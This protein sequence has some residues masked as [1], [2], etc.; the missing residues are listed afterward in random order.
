MSTS[1]FA[2]TTKEALQWNATNASIG[3]PTVHLWPGQRYKLCV[4]TD[5]LFKLK[6]FGAVA[7]LFVSPVLRVIQTFILS[8][9]TQHVDLV[10]DTTGCSEAG[11]AFLA[12]DCGVLIES[13]EQVLEE[14]D[15]MPVGD[16]SQTAVNSYPFVRGAGIT[17]IRSAP[18]QLITVRC[19][20]SCNASSTA[21]LATICDTSDYS[22]TKTEAVTGFTTAS[23]SL[24][25]GPPESSFFEIVF[26]A[27]PLTPGVA[28]RLCVDLDGSY[29]EFAF[30]DSTLQVHT[31]GAYTTPEPLFG[32]G[33]Q[34]S[35]I[36]DASSLAPGRNY[37]VCIDLDGWA[38]ELQAG[39]TTLSVYINDAK[40]ASASIPALRPSENQSL[41]FTC[42]T[43]C[44]V[45]ST[46]FVAL[47]NV[48]CNGGTQ[49][50]VDGVT[51]SALTPSRSDAGSSLFELSVN[52]TSLIEGKYYTL[53][54][55]TDGFYTDL[56]FGATNIFAYISPTSMVSPLTAQRDIEQ[57][58]TITCTICSYDTMVYL[59][60]ICDSSHG[61]GALPD[62]RKSATAACQFSTASTSTEPPEPLANTWLAA[63]DAKDLTAG[64]YYKLCI[65]VD[66]Q[67][68]AYSYGD[69]GF[70]IYVSP[71]AA[72]D[73]S[74]V[75]RSM[76]APLVV[77]C[78]PF[79]ADAAAL[80]I[81]Y[82][83]TNVSN[84]D[85]WIA[86]FINSH[87]STDNSSKYPVSPKTVCSEAS[88]GYLS[89]SCDSSVADGAVASLGVT[90]SNIAV[91]TS[92]WS[93]QVWPNVF[94]GASLIEASGD[95]GHNDASCAQVASA[96][97]YP[98]WT[99]RLDGGTCWGI[100]ARMLPAAMELPG[101]SSGPSA[102]R[103][104]MASLDTRNLRQG[105]YYKLCFDLDGKN[106]TQRTGDTNWIVFV[107]PVSM[108]FTIAVQPSPNQVISIACN[109]CTA[110]SELYLST[111]CDS[112][113]VAGGI[114]GKQTAAST[115]RGSDSAWSA[116]QDA[117]ILSRGTSYQVCIDH[118]PGF[119]A[120]G[121]AGFAISVSP[122]T[123]T[124]ESVMPQERQLLKLTCPLACP[125]GES[126][127]PCHDVC[128]RRTVAQIT[129]G[130]CADLDHAGALR[131]RGG[132]PDWYIVL[133]ARA[134]TI[135]RHY[136]ICVDID[137]N[138]SAY[139]M[140]D[141]GH[142]VYVSPLNGTL[143]PI[144]RPEADQSV[145]VTTVPEYTIFRDT[146][147]P[148]LVTSIPAIGFAAV[149]A[150]WSAP[151]RLEFDENVL[152]GNM[153]VELH[154][155]DDLG[156][157]API[158]VHPPPAGDTSIAQVDG[159]RRALVLTF[160]TA[161]QAGMG[162]FT[163]HDDV[164]GTAYGTVIDVRDALFEQHRV[165][166]RP[167]E[168]LAP[169]FYYVTASGS[170]AIKSA[171]E[172]V[173]MVS[174]LDSRDVS[175]NFGAVAS[176]AD[177]TSPMLVSSILD[178]IYCLNASGVL[179]NLVLRMSEDIQTVN[180]AS[181]V[182][183][184]ACWS[185]P[186]SQDNSGTQLWRLSASASGVSINAMAPNEVFVATGL[187]APDVNG[188]E[189]TPLLR[190]AHYRL[191]LAAGALAD[192][193]SP[194][195]VSPQID[196]DFNV[197]DLRLDTPVSN[198]AL[199]AFAGRPVTPVRRQRA[200]RFLVEIGYGAVQDAHGNNNSVVHSWS[201]TNDN[202]GPVLDPLTSHPPI[203]S[204]S[205]MPGES[206]YL[207]FNEVVQ[208]GIGAFELWS[209]SAA[210]SVNK[211]NEVSLDGVAVR[212]ADF[213]IPVSQA[214][215]SGTRVRITPKISCNCSELTAGTTYY[216]STG[217]AAGVLLDAVGNP[218]ASLNTSATWYFSVATTK[219]GDTARPEIAHAGGEV[220]AGA[221]SAF[222]RFTEQV[223]TIENGP[224]LEVVDCGADFNCSETS[225]NYDPQLIKLGTMSLYG[226]EGGAVDYGQLTVSLGPSG[227]R[228]LV[229]VPPAVVQDTASNGPAALKNYGPSGIYSFEVDGGVPNVGGPQWLA[230]D[231]HPRDQY[232]EGI[233]VS[234]YDNVILVFDEA[235]QVGQGFIE[236]WDLADANASFFSVNVSSL[237]PPS[238]FGRDLISGTHVLIT[239]RTLCGNPSCPDLLPSTNYYVGVSSYD[240]FLNKQGAPM[241][242]LPKNN[243]TLSD[244]H[245]L[246]GM[247]MFYTHDAISADRN[248]PAV[249]FVAGTF[250]FAHNMLTGYIY[251]TERLTMVTSLMP[252]TWIDCG[253][254]FSCNTTDDSVISVAVSFA[255]APA[256]GD[257]S[258]W[259]NGLLRY[260]VSLPMRNRRYQWA[261]PAQLVRDVAG[262]YGPDSSFDVIVDYGGLSAGAA[263]TVERSG[264]MSTSCGSTGDAAVLDASSTHAPS[265]AIV[266]DSDGNTWTLTINASTLR[267]GAYY[268]L[269]TDLDGSALDTSGFILS[270]F[271]DTGIEIL[272][273]GLFS[274]TRFVRPRP[275]QL[276]RVECT[277]GCSS[278][279]R[280]HLAKDCDFGIVNGSLTTNAPHHTPVAS[281][282]FVSAGLWDLALDGTNLTTKQSYKLCVDF[283][284]ATTSL[285]FTDTGLTSYCTPVIEADAAGQAVQAAP[286]QTVRLECPKGLDGCNENTRVHLVP[287]PTQ[288]YLHPV[289]CD[290]PPSTIPSQLERVSENVTFFTVDASALTHGGLYTVCLDPDGDNSTE[291][292]GDAG[293]N[294]YVSP[295]RQLHQAFARGY[296]NEAFNVTCFQDVLPP[297]LE[298]FLSNPSTKEAAGWQ[299]N[300]VL[301]FNE[302]V[303]AGAGSFE[304]WDVSG[305]LGVP[306]LSV[307]V[308]DLVTS[309]ASAD[310]I[311]SF[312]GR[313]V[314]LTP[315]LLCPV[316][317]SELSSLGNNSG[318]LVP[319]AS[320]YLRTSRSGVVLDT[321]GLKLA[322]LNTIDS[323]SFR[324]SGPGTLDLRPPEV[325]FAN[326][327]TNHS[328]RL[329]VGSV[330]FT[331]QVIEYSWKSA[332]PVILDCGADKD[333]GRPC[334]NVVVAVGQLL[335]GDGLTFGTHGQLRFQVQLP[336]TTDRL[337]RVTISSG[338]VR[339]LA[340]NPGPR[341]DY[342]TFLDFRESTTAPDTVPPSLDATCLSRPAHKDSAVSMDATIILAFSEIVQAGTGSFELWD[343]SDTALKPAF[344][345]DI[346]KISEMSTEPRASLKGHS[347]LTGRHVY[348][349]PDSILCSASIRGHDCPG[350]SLNTS[351]YLTTN[352]SGAL[353]DVAGN[354]LPRLDTRS[355]WSW[356]TME[357][358][359]MPPEVVFTTGH[360]FSNGNVTG[361]IYFTEALVSV[362]GGLTVIDCGVD[363]D[364]E[365][366]ADNNAASAMSVIGITSGTTLPDAAR[367]PGV[368]YFTA[369][370][371]VPHHRYRV[372]V[373]VGL[374]TG[375][376]GGVVGP[377]IAYAYDFE[378][379]HPYDLG[380]AND[381]TRFT[382]AFLAT[383]CDTSVSNGSKAAVENEIAV[384]AALRAR[385]FGGGY[386]PIAG[387]SA[388]L[389]MP[390]GG[391]DFSLFLDTT[392]L[393]HGLHYKLCVDLDGVVE[394][395]ALSSVGLGF[396][397]TG[398]DIYMAKVS[399]VTR[400]IVASENQSVIFGCITGCSID[401]V[402][403]LAAEDVPCGANVSRGRSISHDENLV[404]EQSTRRGV[405]SSGQW[406][407]MVN[408]TEFVVGRSYK[409][410]T[411]FD[412][413]IFDHSSMRFGDTGLRIYVTPL[414]SVSDVA[415]DPVPGN[416]WTL[417]CEVCSDRSEVYFAEDCSG[418]PV[419]A[420]PRLQKTNEESFWTV[421]LDG[422]L[423]TV[424]HQY[425]LCCDLDGFAGPM[426]PGDSGYDVHVRPTTFLH[427]PGV[428][429]EERVTLAVTCAP[430][431][432]TS[433]T[434]A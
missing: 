32:I 367:H 16:S 98:Y 111:S 266:P 36:T 91:F 317:A 400:T 153:D 233:T 136:H 38:S 315:T 240:V 340:G 93:P 373:P 333:C 27:T 217:G 65:D 206:V 263:P 370:L 18:D 297:Y 89:T 335:L 310:D 262:N 130:S 95:P 326:L 35:F 305:E 388:G 390:Q 393:V 413:R 381:C 276:I 185:A 142:T 193:S 48:S 243:L 81:Y 23:A 260:N 113:A 385:I 55:D 407:F 171:G 124:S 299:E 232:P 34:W 253:H 66:G 300:I 54:I 4:D 140:A 86:D 177:S 341:Y 141:V 225:D 52:A 147:G 7:T 173:E 387:T 321:A 337:Y 122:I 82:N 338:A 343:A 87:D 33:S 49:R 212:A 355:Y 322:K 408:A 272:V 241:Q 164:N 102:V 209:V 5:G 426:T 320:Y 72:L 96:M 204:Y 6:S 14:I 58:L 21:Y 350:L 414:L 184:R 354:E 352:Q 339:D 331:E 220:A 234:V 187:L 419:L 8:E 205:A 313:R 45:A 51:T 20:A 198:V 152:P 105:A 200:R 154:V 104:W 308:A 250:E 245:G 167:S 158:L 271:G 314:S 391:R 247:T 292:P 116:T 1:T 106:T 364:C 17:S 261:L 348:I 196:L 296:S 415:I 277:V 417:H 53:C 221:V 325:A 267:P 70:S 229:K 427:T 22:G 316:N 318:C 223:W 432:C 259:E 129:S 63:L 125:P 274:A 134:L 100:P 159:S 404:D 275:G 365:S 24:E 59:A 114:Y 256:P 201:F 236:L 374:V 15:A 195:Q 312:S 423:G 10:C 182:S 248:A 328:T 168:P 384:A 126:G 222:L 99:R 57:V 156:S 418:A 79:V 431:S 41:F 208:A 149:N 69:T 362:G 77:T 278:A 172:G 85:Y 43:G 291:A 2:G 324:A 293:V 258:L 359:S 301:N 409:L 127:E 119:A 401:A 425:Q 68:D 416:R 264:Y 192:F 37:K 218:L 228:Y 269:C 372:L 9:A 377:S 329:V 174:P 115:L 298:G 268:R 210:P 73:T 169:G 80:P 295:I 239:P 28:Y 175:L 84:L 199:L 334:D 110:S 294:V 361:F 162:S 270:S 360:R 47:T 279:T 353:N 255:V 29:D 190:D 211:T 375:S 392:V 62:Q 78:Y 433:A 194:P 157:V 214:S 139:A 366:T 103:E 412:G 101:F 371:P 369:A 202:A 273:S 244:L 178:G 133:D 252:M 422:T 215:I 75:V 145:R 282:V 346:H 123:A 286:G 397:D 421:E 108:V 379:G 67:G 25:G 402:A 13:L 395:V 44:S 170:A 46:A 161:V 118:D 155:F 224:P 287:I 160:N 344:V 135:G 138:Y 280:G 351:Y 332:A 265:V 251:F 383:A 430:G 434:S 216:L 146:A 327:S 131:F 323:W 42:P 288:S 309:S 345:V 394:R 109:D 376:T 186:C 11:H 94:L 399:Q 74:T 336:S 242:P 61:D 396:G 424:G 143:T 83:D 378:Y 148:V 3:W 150:S 428:G 213:T 303:Q 283:D 289:A 420:A 203:D 363:L 357:N 249:A 188:S 56:D 411:D 330:Y 39:D 30:G 238:S 405:L 356:T 121:R 429:R 132:V 50:G 281:F 191:S 88:M 304:I 181:N 302:N 219:A 342:T 403:H 284:G 120:R 386:V 207:T 230:T 285:G 12:L 358:A 165:F 26:D 137:G 92:L 235:V 60:T 117:S 128:T 290:A 180:L 197:C 254:D 107:T 31:R 257:A 389:L 410:C 179:P 144:I 19:I 237:V 311:T 306:I 97:G 163:I 40:P 398:F 380:E 183:L 307:N 64:S 406:R 382:A 349:T 90:R 226:N 246:I 166:L 319:G 227:R 76:I 368:L 71:V 347:L 151:V 231:S 176:A 189:R 112:G